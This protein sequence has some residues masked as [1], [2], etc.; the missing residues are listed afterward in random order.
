[1]VELKHTPGPWAINGGRIVRYIDGFS[2]P[3]SCIATVGT[4]NAQTPTDTAN[5]R[6][7]AAAPDLLDALK[8]LFGYIENG[9]LVRNITGDDKPD[10]AVKLLPFMTTLNKV[11]AAIAKTKGRVL[12]LAG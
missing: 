7:I 5:A 1:M 8:D 12:P 6:L 3:D 10:W 9:T 2:T 4:V 11:Q